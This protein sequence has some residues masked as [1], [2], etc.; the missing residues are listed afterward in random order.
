LQ[1]IAQIQKECCKRQWRK[2]T[3]QLSSLIPLNL[4]RLMLLSPVEA[5]CWM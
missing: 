2:I 3:W 4:P 1:K 5:S